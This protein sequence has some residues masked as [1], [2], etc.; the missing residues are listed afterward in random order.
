[1]TRNCLVPLSAVVVVLGLSALP[2]W[3]G[4]EPVSDATLRS[5]IGASGGLSSL[6]PTNCELT[7]V[8]AANGAVPPPVNLFVSDDMC[9]TVDNSVNPPAWMYQNKPCISCPTVGQSIKL[10]EPVATG[11]FTGPVGSVDCGSGAGGQAMGQKGTCINGVCTNKQAYACNL[12]L[13]FYVQQHAD[14]PGGGGD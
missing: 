11:G 14:D 10:G 2:A 9:G 13:N 7:Q 12:A 4:Y 6:G 1:M 5:A 8:D 3:D